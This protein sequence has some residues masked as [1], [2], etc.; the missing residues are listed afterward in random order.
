MAVKFSDNSVVKNPSYF[1]SGIKKE[2]L[3]RY[4][5]G[6]ICVRYL[7]DEEKRVA[8][9]I[10][11]AALADQTVPDEQRRIG[12]NGD[13]IVTAHCF[14]QPYP[15][16]IVVALP[17]DGYAVRDKFA[18]DG[19]SVSV[20]DCNLVIEGLTQHRATSVLLKKA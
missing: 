18:Q 7:M 4:E 2:I 16:K 5:M 19:L 1:M 13:V 14:E 20:V 17:S 11:P 10:V 12:D 9:S 15:E 8:L 6:S 3:A